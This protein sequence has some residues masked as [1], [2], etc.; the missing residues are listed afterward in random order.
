MPSIE[1]EFE[2]L[3]GDFRD[4]FSGAQNVTLTRYAAGASYNTTTMARSATTSTVSAKAV[5]GG[6]RPES[7]GGG[8]SIERV[9][10]DFAA[11]DLSDVPPNIGDTITDP[12]VTEGGSA[13]VYRIVAVD[14][15]TGDK[16]YK[17]R[18][19]SGAG[20]V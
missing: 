9:E 4:T 13:K 10:Y 2:T 1:D 6:L 15:L 20:G 12:N 17:C 11:A 14:R 18:C 3:A 7:M 8:K 16:V 19:V 5:R